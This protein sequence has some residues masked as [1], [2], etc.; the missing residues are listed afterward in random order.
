MLE[1]VMELPEFVVVEV[2]LV[3]DDGGGDMVGLGGDEEAVDEA[4]RGAWE[5]EGGHDAEEVDI[6]GDDVCLLGE[7]SGASDDVVATVV[8]IGDKSGAVVKEL[9]VDT[10]A[11]GNGVGLLGAVKAV[12]A[13]EA[14]R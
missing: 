9:E 3:E 11:H 1:I 14:A 10:V 2:A 5:A 8:D 13:A 12:V 7:V 4:G 6:G